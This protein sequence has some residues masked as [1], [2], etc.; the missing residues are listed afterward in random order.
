M[1]LQIQIFN[2]ALIFFPSAGRGFAECRVRGSSK[3]IFARVL[4]KLKRLRQQRSRLE[5]T[6]RLRDQNF[7]NLQSDLLVDLPK[8]HPFHFVKEFSF[9]SFLLK[10][11]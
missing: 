10:N 6:H 1:S 4:C 11:N 9:I 8:V 5:A 3:W 2:F 7:Q